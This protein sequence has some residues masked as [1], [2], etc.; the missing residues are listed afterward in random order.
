MPDPEPY[1]DAFSAQAEKWSEWYTTFNSL[2]S[3]GQVP[4]GETFKALSGWDRKRLNQFTQLLKLQNQ[5]NIELLAAI[6]E[7]KQQ[8]GMAKGTRMKSDFDSQINKPIETLR[9][10]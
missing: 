10:C 2:S 9:E 8:L 6:D 5:V 7:I 3:Q 4:Q 1:V